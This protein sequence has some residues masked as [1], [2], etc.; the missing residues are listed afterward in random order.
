MKQNNIW[1]G[2]L[3]SQEKYVQFTTGDAAFFSSDE[4]DIKDGVLRT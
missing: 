3:S 2:L 4:V 1:F